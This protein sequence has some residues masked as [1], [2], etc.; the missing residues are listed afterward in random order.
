MDKLL[1][2]L[3]EYSSHTWIKII[4]GFFIHNLEQDV[5]YSHYTMIFSKPYGFI[6]WLVENDKINRHN[7][8]GTDYWW[9][10]NYYW[11]IPNSKSAKEI[12][13][14]RLLMILSIQ[15]NPIDFLVSVLK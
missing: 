10:L 15:D 6:K 14:E 11:T 3:N 2:V 8:K 4:E 13:V 9:E 12:K 7:V 1:K 5:P